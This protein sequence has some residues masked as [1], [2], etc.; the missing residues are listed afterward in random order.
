[1]DDYRENGEGWLRRRAEDLI[2]RMRRNPRSMALP[3]G[4]DLVHELLVHQAELQIQNRDLRDT[5]DALEISRQRYLA[6]FDLAPVGY[7]ILDSDSVVLEANRMACQMLTMSHKNLIGKPMIALVDAA[8][9]EAFVRY[10]RRVF[11]DNVP[12]RSGVQSGCELLMPG[13]GGGAFFA[14]VESMVM[15]EPGSDEVRC[16][17]TITDVT[18]QKEAAEQRRELESRVQQAQKLQSL[19]VLAGGIAHDFNN[20]LVGI[21]GHADLALLDLP[22]AAPARSAIGEIR[23]AALRAAELSN[24]M[25]AY[26]GQGSFV[27]GPVVLNELLVEV[28]QLLRSALPDQVALR[29]HLAADLPPIDGDVSQLKQVLFN[30]L[31][32]AAEAIG[33]SAG[34]VTLRTSVER[35]SH[36]F[37]DPRLTPE[38]LPEGDY[39]QLAIEDTGCGMDEDTLERIFEP[40]F[41]TKFTGRGLGLAAVLGIVRGHHGALRTSS[42]EGRGTVF[43]IVFPFSASAGSTSDQPITKPLA[44]RR[45]PIVMLV[46]DDETTRSVGERMLTRLGY[47]FE[48]IATG[49]EAQELL[50]Q[51]SSDF[52]AIILEMALPGIDGA[53]TL[54][55]LRAL[56][57]LVPVVLTS[58]HHSEQFAEL[59]EGEL[60]Q[61]FLQ[62]PFNVQQLAEVIES[63]LGRKG[64]GASS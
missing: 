28:E 54:T 19:R 33:E 36:G 52:S 44:I 14:H 42:Q 20:L 22:L 34:M 61:G 63:V 3:D 24:Q 13:R 16:L 46:D 58:G 37:F 2:D 23:R 50:R 7:V 1:M 26:S 56:N 38:A 48:L 62:K 45:K 5:Q 60:A 41:S 51:R 64:S 21:L 47:G 25:L 39:V 8:Y 57:P 53:S 30:L 6:L 32:N 49:R 17:T 43:Q 31:T 29:L 12:G 59:L 10:Q 27:V 4:A 55:A 11:R 40:F 15:G 35:V 9:H 18:T